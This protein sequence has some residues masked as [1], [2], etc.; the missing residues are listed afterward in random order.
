[1][2]AILDKYLDLNFYNRISKRDFHLQLK[3]HPDYP[4]VKAI[5]DTLDYF[6]VDNVA[7]TIPKEKFE[8]LPA[9]FIALLGTEEKEGYA[10]VEKSEGKVGLEFDGA[11]RQRTTV[12]NFLDRWTGAIVAIEVNDRK[13]G[14]TIPRIDF[15]LP[16]V[17]ALLLGVQFLDFSFL[18]FTLVFLSIVGVYLSYLMLQAE[19]GIYSEPVVAVCQAL[20]K[21]ASCGEVINAP[22]G[23]L[24]GAISLSDL[25][26][27]YFAASTI[28]Y[29][30]I[31]FSYAFALVSSVVGLPVLLFSLYQQGVVIKRWC[32]ICLF[33]LFTI[34]MQDALVVFNSSDL[35]FS[36]EYLLKALA[37]MGITWGAWKQIKEKFIID[38]QLQSSQEQSLKF[39]RNTELFQLLL[40]RKSVDNTLIGSESRIQFGSTTPDLTIY[41]STN[42]FCGYCVESFK[43]YHKLL[44][45]HGTRIQVNII[46]NVAVDQ[47]DNKATQIAARIVDIYNQQ[48]PD[49]AFKS[50]L[51][52][53]SDRNEEA[54][55]QAYGESSQG[56][57]SA[58]SIL[59]DHKRWCKENRVTY[60][61]ATI[62]DD[63]IFPIEYKINELTFFV[64][65]LLLTKSKVQE[66]E[67]VL[68]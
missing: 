9:R 65:E 39:K 31:G 15:L 6:G 59:K 56:D 18:P 52:W 11:P 33:A 43:V 37:V 30:V 17:G 13:A 49:E 45:S 29:T 21:N 3:S 47:P 40:N 23:K 55:F 22:T 66:A 60:T 58:S 41:A 64:E 20:S 34:L 16:I 38:L 42:P 10:L 51:S 63:H 54:W 1:M 4:H 68:E 7:I 14:V 57:H 36:L 67:L 24:F 12:Q 44:K 8:Q 19:I 53:Y 28:V 27:A 61:P 2:V 35:S 26:M 48:G 25:S 5:T 46:F 32:G 62:V 50:L